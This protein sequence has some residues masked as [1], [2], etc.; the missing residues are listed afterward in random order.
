MELKE[1]K[2]GHFF[3]SDCVCDGL[4]VSC[5][6]SCL[7]R[8][9]SGKVLSAEE[10]S[11]NR[12]HGGLKMLSLKLS[13][14]VRDSFSARLVVLMK[15]NLFSST[16]ESGRDE[17][18]LCSCFLLNQQPQCSPGGCSTILKYYYNVIISFDSKKETALIFL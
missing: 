7:L 16:S 10:T 3:S 11:C 9:I 12:S 6:G 8:F 14:D 17:G 15:L 18:K 13:A 4:E 5:S 1:A 2:A